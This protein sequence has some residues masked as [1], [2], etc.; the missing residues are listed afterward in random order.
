MRILLTLP[1]YNEEQGLEDVLNSFHDI[2]LSKG[3]R[4][5]AVVV[6]DGSRD[7][8][9]SV[10]RQWAARMPVELIEHPQNMGLG[11][12]IR[13]GLRRA[14][15]LAQPGDIIVTMDADNTHPPSLI[16]QMVSRIDG[17]CDLVIA[18]RFQPGARVTGLSLGR[19]ILSLGARWL[20]TLL[21]PIP[22]ARDYT[23][24]YRAFRADFL[25]AALRHYGA[26]LVTEPGFT[27]TAEI[28]VKLARLKPVICEVPLVLHYG[29]KH[30]R[31]KMNVPSTIR[32]TLAFLVK[33]VLLHPR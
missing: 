15:D 22:G 20:F 33:S 1:A 31:S 16:P 29:Q 9:A 28:L 19:H 3:W 13:D 21:L 18:S 7:G 14:V 8:T 10:A 26:R 2:L 25:A 24:G 30:G 12:S 5:S 17:G 6:D 32:T 4:G 23:C 27:S 11:A